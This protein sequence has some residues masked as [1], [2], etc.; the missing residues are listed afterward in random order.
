MAATLFLAGCVAPPPVKETPPTPAEAPPA[1][2]REF[3]GVWV[4][5][6]ANID[7][8][9][10]PGLPVEQQKTEMRVILDR[11]QALKLNAIILQVRP[12]A[13]ALYAS[14]LEPWS[15][16]LTGKQ[17]TAP[18]P[19]YDPL[20]TWIEEAHQ[21]GLELH[22]WFN[23]YRARHFAAKSELAAEHIAR[24]H[25]R[26]V[27]TY[28]DHLWMDPGEPVAAKRTLAV[29]RE[30]VRNY[31]V[32]GV[33]IDD[34]FY[35]YPIPAPGAEPAKE[36]EERATVEFPDG[37]AWEEYVAGG[38]RLSRADWR[39]WNVNHLVEQIHRAVREAK[40]W[41]RFGVSPF[42]L[43][44]PDRRPPGIKG[45]SQYDKLYA[46][47]ELW[48]QRGW[49]DYLA[50]Q[51]YWPIEQTAQSFPVLL[52]YWTEQN[53]AQRHVWPGLFTSRLDDTPKSWNPVEIVKQIE[54]IRG[55]GGTTGHIHF[56][57]ISL[58]QDRHRIGASL[59]GVY[60]QVALVPASPWLRGEPLDAP[61]LAV[62]AQGDAGATLAIDPAGGQQPSRYA[63][64]QRRGAEWELSLARG[65]SARVA[66]SG[67]AADAIVVI[68][69]DRAG[70]EGAPATHRRPGAAAAAAA[71][72][73]GASQQ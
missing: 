27:K 39:R 56:S 58:V 41:V 72:G 6:V 55:N 8:P 10:R 35:P 65:P 15:E 34:Y 5:T 1:L 28:G 59:Q 73:H 46:D 32:D 16:Y 24:T 17:G 2:P 12:A 61:R 37:P 21:R 43:G 66:L 30:V 29:I 42:G 19:Y 23:P 4:A 40:P 62:E 3:R 57:M 44:R 22:A 49:M 53:T 18:D 64:W 68:P 52:K 51:L 50:P 48:L 38:G 31:D 69:I 60:P 26:A 33:H 36:G 7:W 54:L 67:D 71:T 47:V 70:N 45:F 20:R 25:P 13:D 9:S 11:A 14:T 63:I